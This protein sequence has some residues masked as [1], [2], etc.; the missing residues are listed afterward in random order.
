[1]GRN[2]TLAGEEF[3]QRMMHP[4]ER[5]A[6]GNRSNEGTYPSNVVSLQE[7]RQRLERERLRRRVPPQPSA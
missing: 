1:M 3:F 7:F 6:V 2:Y 5:M 4:E